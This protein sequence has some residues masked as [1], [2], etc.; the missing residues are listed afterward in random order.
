MQYAPTLTAENRASNKHL[1][2]PVGSFGGRM[3]LRPTRDNKKQKTNN[4]RIRYPAKLAGIPDALIFFSHPFLVSR[5]EKDVGVRGQRPLP[6]YYMRRTVK[7]WPFPSS[8]TRL[9]RGVLWGVFFCAPTLTAEKGRSNNE[10][11]GYPAKLA[12][13][14]DALIF[15]SFPFLASRQ[16]KERSPRK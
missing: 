7:I 6:P 15:F 2:A 10:K 5:Q 13:I 11:A 12:G 4:E 16:E 1:F 14:P 8:C 3:L 9:Y